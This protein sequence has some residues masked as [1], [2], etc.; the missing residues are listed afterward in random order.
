MSDKK[1]SRDY[2][3]KRISDFDFRAFWKKLDE[4]YFKQIS[5]EEVDDKIEKIEEMLEVST[6]D[7]KNSD[8]ALYLDSG[9]NL[10][11]YAREQDSFERAYRFMYPFAAG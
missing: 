7:P 5:E 1:G 3:P 11:K 2:V 6:I 4:T 8:D 10:F 9:L